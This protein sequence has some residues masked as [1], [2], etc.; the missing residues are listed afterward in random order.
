MIPG[1]A[2]PLLLRSAAPTAYQVSRSLRFNG[3]V[4]S[5]YLSRTP[6]SAG[7]RKTWTWSGWVKRSG[8][9]TMQ[10]L[11]SAWSGFATELTLLQ[12]TSDD[13]LIYYFDNA[14]NNYRFTTAQVFRDC[15]SWYHLL[16]AVDTTQA[17]NTNRAKLYVNGSQV[18]AFSQY[19]TFPPSSNTFINSTFTHNVGRYVYDGTRYFSGYLADIHLI[20]GQALTPSSF[21]EFDT[22]N[23]W[24]PKAY[25][26]SYGTNG[27]HLDFA[28]N[29]AATAAALGKDTSGNG[30]NW[31][32]N[33]LSIVTGGPTSVAAASGALP[34]YNT[35]DTYGATKGTGT[36]TDSNSGSIVLAV[37]MDGANNGTTFTDESATIKGSG[38]AKSISRSGDTKTSTAQSKFYGSSG[39]FDGSGDNLSLNSSSD[40]NLGTGL[41]T[42]EFW[43]NFSSLPAFTALVNRH[44]YG[45]NTGWG[46]W[47][48]SDGKLSFWVNA[49]AGTQIGG[50]KA[51]VIGQWHHFAVVRDS[52]NLVTIYLDGVANGSATIASFNDASTSLAI[53][54]SGTWNFPYPLTG[55]L[56]DLRIYKGAAK[57]TSN[58][59][60]PSSTQNATVA[61]GNDSTVDSPT[62]GTASSGGDAGGVTVG[63]Y[64]TLN[65]TIAPSNRA[66]LSNGNLD[67]TAIDS[68]STR[69]VIGTFYVSSG[70]WYWE[71]VINTAAGTSAFAYGVV[72]DAGTSY[73]YYALTGDKYIGVSASSYGA[74]WTTGD[75][76]GTALDMDAG[77]VTFYKNG[78]S[79]GTAFSGLTGSFAPR[80]TANG[81]T[82]YTGTFN[83]GQRPFAYT[84]PS[85]FKALNTANLPTPTIAKG[86]D[87]FDVKLYTGNGS[88]QT[89]SG[90]NFSPDW[91]WIK[92]RDTTFSHQLWDA[93]R[94]TN[95]LLS[96]NSTAAEI[97]QTGGLTAFNSDG[98]SVGDESPVNSTSRPFVAWCWDGGSSTVSNTQGSITS[99]VRANASAGFSIVTYTGDGSG[100]ADTPSGDTVGHG[101]GV[102]P[103][104]I[105]GKR[106]DSANGWQVYHG[107]LANTQ[108]IEL[109]STGAAVTSAMW[110]NSTPTSTTIALGNNPQI[111]ATGSTYVLYC[112]APVAGYSGAFTYTGNGSSDG[113]MVYL[114][115]RPRFIIQKRT[116]SA[117][118]WL[119]IDTARDP[120]NVARNELFA[121]SSAAEYDN[122]SLLDVLSN[123]FK[124][125]ATF[126]N[127][128][129]SGGSF[130]GF[131]FAESPFAYAR[132][133]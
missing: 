68:T 53:G 19:D 41:F 12:F 114:G 31:T 45:A 37:A 73:V 111:N 89:I 38:S 125:R 25:S 55:Y 130:I 15:S 76:I 129:A 115:F 121:N 133:R 127:M 131:A 3:S 20:D 97:S 66:A 10:M 128:N 32:P 126:A 94:G 105:I 81:G 103:K 71:S 6:G 1:S 39:Y 5:S 86:S 14:A 106:R 2:N 117:G 58:F 123:G 124:I 109:N 79:Q 60:P 93:I 77:T 36:R 69:G 78:V 95:K 87:Y 56:S 30:N 22:N 75:T 91:V 17:V 18:T 13:T 116:D 23:V 46:I 49:S 70:K 50:A 118:S 16:L 83:F 29:S 59:N 99:Q 90:L 120:V 122:T 26:G 107:S 98:F 104:L 4:D 57:Y 96:S 21:G 51:C 63:N 82:D 67:F 24:Q 43:V 28:D 108:A 65:P 54:D 52:N 92:V 8:L 9:G 42:I 35:T 100:T 113:P 34:I 11:L 132:A 101:L 40:F 80:G 7:N 33:N 62:N 88:T 72:N 27:F 64:C 47:T 102:A 85:G 84:A 110:G 61:A 74:T 112:F 48:G 119:L 44:N